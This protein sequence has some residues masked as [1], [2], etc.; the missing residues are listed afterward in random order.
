MAVP[1]PPIDPRFRAPVKLVVLLGDD[2]GNRPTI[3]DRCDWLIPVSFTRDFGGSSL[4]SID[5]R[6]DLYKCNQ[7]LQDTLLPI[8]LNKLVEVRVENPN[9]GDLDQVLAW[10]NIAR[11]PQSI[12]ETESV[13]LVARFDPFLFGTRFEGYPIRDPNSGFI[14]TVRKPL[15]FNPVIDDQRMRNRSD[16]TG[17]DVANSAGS[18]DANTN[19][20][21]LT[22]GVGT[23]GDF[24][25][26][27]VAGNT[28]LDGLTDHRVGDVLYFDGV[29]WQPGLDPARLIIEPES[30]RTKPARD[31]HG[32]IESRWDLATAVQR[33]CYT[34]N[35]RQRHFKNPTLADLQAVLGTDTPLLENHS[36]AFGLSLPEAL[37]KLLEPHGYTHFIKHTVDTAG[38]D[39]PLT[40]TIRVAERGRG[41]AVTLRLQRL[42]DTI[43]SAKTNIDKFTA[44]YDPV[45][46][47]NVIIGHTALALR[48]GTFPLRPAWPQTDDSLSKAELTEE[49]KEHDRQHIDVYAKFVFDTAGDYNS[50][51]DDF[52]DPPWDAISTLF[53]KATSPMRRRFKPALTQGLDR[54]P[55]GV[56]G[57]LLEW[58]DGTNWVA[59]PFS[60]SV[61]QHEAGVMIEG[62]VPE[63][64]RTEFLKKTR[65]VA[66]GDVAEPILRITCSLQGD[67]GTTYTAS[68]LSTSANGND[69]PV[70]Y[71]FSHKFA[72][73][74]VVSSGDFQ[75]VLFTDRH[76]PVTG[77]TVVGN[78]PGEV[79][80]GIDL[81]SVLLP[82]DRVNIVDSTDNDG[83]YT[84]DTVTYSAPT[85]T[86]LLR[87]PLAGLTAVDGSL[88]YLTEEEAPLTKLKRMCDGIQADESLTEIHASANLFGIDHPEYELGQVV[89]KVEFR[90]LSLDSYHVS[91]I[92]QRHPQISKLL[93]RVD[94]EQS[95][96]IIL[97][98]FDRSA[99]NQW[100]RLQTK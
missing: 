88:C 51:R 52:S 65:S 30:I 100:K 62:G 74:R 29:K 80:V 81:S 23:F 17:S 92:E 5:F 16:M 89:T 28:E 54:R 6:I 87:E 44:S 64:F 24:L 73:A 41:D 3:T 12:S 48:E 66:A 34:L 8:G 39:F 98:Q 25:T 18:W 99:Y 59:V 9:T 22:S 15:I 70:P 60:F 68:R 11:Q 72:D 67:S 91:A 83:V 75:S 93:Y 27:T 31:L 46:R 57:Y 82:G 84:V 90:N 2:N 21:T 56:N 97:D 71:D 69:N 47:P 4:D 13:G 14:V 1:P 32:A 76:T 96:E 35:R 26:V 53:G 94:G 61:L 86:I 77:Y 78:F 42:A 7:R 55:I 40:S 63:E 20:P 45:K 79:K 50:L 43:D 37:D 58:N 33:L 49:R 36:I 10:G 19:S 85:T 95:L 38:S